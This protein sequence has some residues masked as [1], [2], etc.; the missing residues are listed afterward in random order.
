MK[1][2]GRGK[3]QGKNNFNVCTDVQFKLL[4]QLYFINWSAVTV[5]ATPL[6]VQ[7]KEDI[8]KLDHPRRT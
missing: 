7:S 5:I 3:Y 4:S 8:V 2:D 1:L 6:N